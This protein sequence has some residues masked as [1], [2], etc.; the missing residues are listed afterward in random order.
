MTGQGDGAR[1]TRG[2]LRGGRV[3]SDIKVTKPQSCSTKKGKFFLYS[4]FKLKKTKSA[5]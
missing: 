3:I 5:F 2:A 1:N 4:T